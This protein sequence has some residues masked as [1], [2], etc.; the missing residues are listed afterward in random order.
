MGSPKKT[1]AYHFW[2]F[3]L[4][5]VM[6]T[7]LCCTLYDFNPLPPII[8]LVSKYLV[9]PHVYTKEELWSMN[10]EDRPV[11]AILGTIYDVSSGGK[12]Y[13]KPSQYAAFTG[14]DASRAFVTGLYDDDNL[15]DRLDGLSPEDCIALD[16]WSKFYRTND[17]YKQLGLVEGNFWDGKGAKTQAMLDFEGCL[18]QGVEDAQLV[19]EFI[20]EFPTCS[21]SWSKGKGGE[22]ACKSSYKGGGK[23][24][25]PRMAP[26]GHK[27]HGRCAC[28][29]V[30]HALRHPDL[31]QYPG[32]SP[33]S[34]VCA[35]PATQSSGE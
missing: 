7:L 33:E 4:V 5:I 35:L 31:V 13:K 29:T 18:R 25:V 15:H 6:P 10:Q 20:S 19:K 27:M 28:Y 26:K 12:H 9:K 1:V 11:L 8:S 24:L 17:D 16:K 30:E 34:T 3:I 32:C 21:S 23:T 14:R 2:R 22:V